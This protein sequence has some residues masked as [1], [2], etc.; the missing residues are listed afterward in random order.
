M[1][2]SAGASGEIWLTNRARPHRR[3]NLVFAVVSRTQLATHKA[4][5]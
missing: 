4:F 2:F 1:L 5:S 3:I